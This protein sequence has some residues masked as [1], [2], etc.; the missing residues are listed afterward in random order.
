MKFAFAVAALAAILS[1]SPA[2]AKTA[3]P[4]S[5]DPKAV[6]AYS[7]AAIGRTLSDHRFVTAQGNARLLSDYR[8][9][10][11]VVNLIYTGCVYSCPL[12]VEAL[13]RANDIARKALGPDRYRI[14]TIGFDPRG[15]TPDRMRAY[16][17]SRG[18]D[19]P[20]WDFLSADATTAAAFADELGFLIEESSAGFEHIAQISVIDADG[21]VYQHVYGADFDPPAVVEPLKSLLLKGGA[22]PA[23]VA[24]LIERVRLFCTTYDSALGRY[25]L[26]YSI[27]IMLVIGGGILLGIG[28]VLVRAAWRAFGRGGGTGG[29]PA[30]MRS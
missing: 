29:G 12:V 1:L 19:D 25:S 24:A 26:D 2:V 3:R 7:Q 17:R 10:P 13:D 6:I 21:R 8:G 23:S 22:A 18:I 9:Q 14:V 28:T 20:N 16:A 4:S 30:I 27:V 15:D 11:L 5:A